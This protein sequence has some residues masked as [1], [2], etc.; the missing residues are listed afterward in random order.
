MLN[1]KVQGTHKECLDKN[2]LHIQGPVFT[3]KHP[4]FFKETIYL[5]EVKHDTQED[6]HDD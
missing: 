2:T 5:S 6:D 4:Y 3:D 1:H